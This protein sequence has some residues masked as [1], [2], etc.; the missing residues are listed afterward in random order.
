MVM[1]ANFFLITMSDEIVVKITGSAAIGQDKSKSRAE[2]AK[3][4]RSQYAVLDFRNGRG[5]FDLIFRYTGG[6]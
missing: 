3:T 5:K 4:Y 6:I 1:A 2:I